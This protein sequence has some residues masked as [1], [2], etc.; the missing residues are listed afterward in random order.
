M[1]DADCV[2]DRSSMGDVEAL[3]I[4]LIP[5]AESHLNSRVGPVSGVN[6]SRRGHVDHTFHS[7][8]MT[9]SPLPDSVSRSEEV[10]ALGY[11]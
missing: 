11:H 7:R 4:F 3:S 6:L 8:G 1:A 5:Q 9:C 2:S 10:T